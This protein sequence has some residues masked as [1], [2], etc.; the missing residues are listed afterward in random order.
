MKKL[1]AVILVLIPCVAGAFFFSPG[2]SG[3][4]GGTFSGT[5]ISWD[6]VTGK[7][8]SLVAD[9]YV[10][11]T[12]ILDNT[13]VNADIN[14]AAGIVGSKLADATID[15]AKIRFNHDLGYSKYTGG[16]GVRLRYHFTDDTGLGYLTL[17]DNGMASIA[18]TDNAGTWEGSLTL[19]IADGSPAAYLRA[20]TGHAVKI[21]GDNVVIVGQLQS[22]NVAITGGTISGVTITGSVSGNAGTATALAADPADCSAGQVATGI[23]ASGALSCTANPSVTSMT[24]GEFISS[25]ADNTRGVTVPNTADPTGANLAAGKMWVTDNSVKVRS[26]DNT[27][28]F[29]AGSMTKPYSFGIDNVAD[30]DDVFIWMDLPRAITITKITC[31]ASV[32]NVVGS[33]T[34]C[35]AA[36]VTSCTA[37]DSTDFTIGGATLQTTATS[38]DSGFENAGIAA[39]A[40]LKWLTTSAPATSN[41]LSCTIQYRE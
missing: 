26:N 11:S 35:T 8:T 30:S 19:G 31:F 12:K 4:G 25:A 38:F 21:Q 10:S 3:G 36:D 20:N 37:V 17:R 34:E 15:M 32:D 13:I 6:N 16:T 40:H 1:L 14:S 9:G 5:E 24:A 18:G 41:K 39:G 33:L 23:A 7:P 29:I 27:V 22:D 2:G 28:T